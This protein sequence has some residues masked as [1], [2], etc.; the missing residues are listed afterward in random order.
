MAVIRKQF[1][2][3]RAMDWVMVILG[4]LWHHP[5][6]RQD[7]RN[8][9]YELEFAETARAIFWGLTSVFVREGFMVLYIA[10]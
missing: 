10:R 1:R 6:G 9:G 5:N 4:S 2:G 7:D 8:R 3:A